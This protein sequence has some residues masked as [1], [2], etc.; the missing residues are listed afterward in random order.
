VQFRNRDVDIEVRARKPGGWTKSAWKKN[1]SALAGCLLELKPSPVISEQGRGGRSAAAA[2]DPVSELG[3][4][5]MRMVLYVESVGDRRARSDEILRCT[6]VVGQDAEA[7]PE[8]SCV[9][10]GRARGLSVSV[11][12][13]SPARRAAQAPTTFQFVNLGFV[14][15]SINKFAS[16][17][18]LSRRET[19]LADL[20]ARPRP[21]KC[22]AP[23]GEL[24]WDD[25]V[26]GDDDAA[27]GGADGREETRFV[28][29]KYVAPLNGSLKGGCR[30]GVPRSCK[31]FCVA[32][33][34]STR[35]HQ[36]FESIKRIG[37]DRLTLI[38]GPPGTGKSTTIYNGIKYRLPPGKQAIVAAV[39]NQVRRRLGPQ[40]PLPSLDA[41]TPL[42][43]ATRSEQ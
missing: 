3:Q 40:P 1:I 18:E 32:H 25:V 2:P 43:Q 7:L 17:D 33:I 35:S 8:V 19:S 42:A 37:C 16:A 29:I 21:A 31:V 36:Q 20:L 5:K 23:Q 6:W 28:P 15:P 34:H 38:Q 22:P 4:P 27:A 39:T 24:E 13:P 14:R 9:D 41:A 26:D 11:T 12:Q 10:T 30:G